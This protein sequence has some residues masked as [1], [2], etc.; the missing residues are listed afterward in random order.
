LK[1]DCKIS[2]SFKQIQN[3]KV[4]HFSMAKVIKVNIAVTYPAQKGE[5]F[6]D[7]FGAKKVKLTET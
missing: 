5:N 6:F 2:V 4:L 7:K 1:D 3:F